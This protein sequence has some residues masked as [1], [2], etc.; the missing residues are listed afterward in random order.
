[1]TEMVSK[2]RETENVNVSFILNSRSQLL[3]GSLELA[4]PRHKTKTGAINEPPM[5]SSNLLIVS[6]LVAIIS[7][8]ETSPIKNLW[9]VKCYT[10]QRSTAARKLVSGSRT[11]MNSCAT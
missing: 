3:N 1:M 6:L 2:N 11:G 10:S 5:S 7:N 9:A 8:S 4:N